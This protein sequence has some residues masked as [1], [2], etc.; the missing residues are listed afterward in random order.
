MNYTITIDTED[1]P[2]QY[3]LRQLVRLGMNRLKDGE[4]IVIQRRDNRTGARFVKTETKDI[5]ITEEFMYG[6]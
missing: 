5:E 4:R 2:L 3:I 6:E 1:H